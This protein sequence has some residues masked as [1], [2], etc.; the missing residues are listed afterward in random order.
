MSASYEDMAKHLDAHLAELDIDSFRAEDINS[1]LNLKTNM[2][3]KPESG[4]RLGGRTS[5]GEEDLLFS[6]SSAAGDHYLSLDS[7]DHEMLGGCARDDEEEEEERVNE[8]IESLSTNCRA[9]KENYTLAFKD[10]FS[11]STDSQ[12]SKE[13]CS[14]D[15]ARKVSWNQL[16]NS[17]NTNQRWECE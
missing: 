17:N 5:V 14:I 4:F 10:S 2:E 8:L 9:N 1:I 11:G 3:Y 6:P 13:S 15:E 7:L 12:S 16:G